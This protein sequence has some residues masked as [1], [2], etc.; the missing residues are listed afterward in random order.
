MTAPNDDHATTSST[1]S[2]PPESEQDQDKAE[3]RDHAYKL[4]LAAAVLLVAS[5]TIV[6]RIAEDWSWVDSFYFSAITVSTVGFGDL[7]PTTDF[8]KLFTVAYIFMG[9]SLLGSVL[10]EWLRRRGIRADRRVQ[11][12]SR[13]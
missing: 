13:D 6:Y 5:A 9:I 4:A 3:F 7:S 1:G 10:N 11:S 8:T 2:P 12:R